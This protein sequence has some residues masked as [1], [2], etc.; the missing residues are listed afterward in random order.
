MGTPWKVGVIG[1]AIFPERTYRPRPPR[2]PPY[3]LR[4]R[5]RKSGWG[6]EDVGS[7]SEAAPRSRNIGT[8]FGERR[9]SP[10]SETSFVRQNWSS[11]ASRLSLRYDEIGRAHA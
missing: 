4:D 3:V 9:T 7:A 6:G 5:D 10:V 2:R 1:V 11:P 8:Q